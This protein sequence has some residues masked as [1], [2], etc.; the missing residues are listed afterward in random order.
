[1]WKSEGEILAP[2]LTL[3]AAAPAWIAPE[4]LQPGDGDLRQPR[5]D[6]IGFPTHHIADQPV[7]RHRRRP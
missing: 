4:P 3:G 2:S 7:A 5:T 1:M 6:P